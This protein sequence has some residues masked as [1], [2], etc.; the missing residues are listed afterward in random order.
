MKLFSFPP[1]NLP[2][3][4]SDYIQR[5]ESIGVLTDGF[6]SLNELL[7]K[8]EKRNFSHEKRSILQERL[9]SQ[10]EN[11]DCSERTKENIDSLLKPS[12]FTVTTG[13]QICLLTGPLYF[14]YKIASTIRLA[15]DLNARD[16][17]KKFV[18][19]YWMATEDHDVAEIDHLFWRGSKKQWAFEE[20][21]PVG[22]LSTEGIVDWV[23]ALFE[24]LGD[25]VH[26][27]FIRTLLDKAYAEKDLASA[28][29]TLVNGLFGRYGLVIIDGNDKAFKSSF[30]EPIKSELF[31][32]RIFEKVS[33]TNRY[34]SSLGAEPA[35]NPREI[36]L[37][38]LLPGKRERII[39]DG[40]GYKVNNTDKKFDSNELMQELVQYP[41]RFSP[42]VLF[43]PIYQEYLLP[44]IAYIGGPGELNYWMQIR[45]AFEDFQVDYPTLILRDQATIVS[46]SVQKKMDK[47]G[48]SAEMIFED[49]DRYI[50]NF[51]S[52]NASI[53]FQAEEEILLNAMDILASKLSAFDRT[54]EASVNA[55]KQKLSKGLENIKAKVIRSEKLRLEQS[56]AQIEFIYNALKPEGILQERRDNFF[57]FQSDSDIDLIQV[58]ID[59]FDPTVPSMKVFVADNS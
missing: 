37:F 17:S 41:E 29:R 11:C 44:N 8:A 38:Y 57:Q 15:E 54:L 49:K 12:T 24:S 55:E 22:L 23:H 27:S 30:T 19:V 35:V 9:I 39:E 31:S 43:R 26:T 51:I 32:K 59:N 45:S 33:E 13:H 50:K 2:P 25:S 14:I 48:L 5:K 36:N 10:Y 42:N 28:T 56:L 46:P 58:W 53:D 21:G 40:E 1:Q 20:K 6:Y 47:L 16:S 7:A 18:P 4:V 3:L 52:E 34:I